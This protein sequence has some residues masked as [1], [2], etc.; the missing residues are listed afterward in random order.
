VLSKRS[1]EVKVRVGGR[2]CGCG[3]V[4]KNGLN[5]HH[6]ARDEGPAR[7]EVKAAATL[8]VWGVVEKHTEGGTRCEL[9]RSSGSGVRV[10]STPEDTE[11]VIA[12]RGTEE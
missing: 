12:W 6:M 1:E 9:V 8:V 7:G 4:R 11:V 5:K 10:A 3:G 2:W